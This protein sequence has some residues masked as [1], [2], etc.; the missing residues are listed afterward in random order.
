MSAP[1]EA[2]YREIPPPARLAPWVECVWTLRAGRDFRQNVLPDGCSDLLLSSWQGG[3]R[4]EVIGAMTRC[5][6]V[7]VRA[8]EAFVGIRFRPGRGSAALPGFEQLTDRTEPLARYW[9]GAARSL[10]GKLMHAAAD[11]EILE[12]VAQALDP[13]EEEEESA[14]Q[15][16]LDLQAMHHGMLSLEELHDTARLGPRQFRRVCLERTGMTPKLLS[17]IL[18]FRRVA[19]ALER[20]TVTS[21][22]ALA[23]DS[24]YCDQA[25]LIRDFRT[26]AGAPPTRHRAVREA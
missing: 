24:G 10:A 5:Q 7:K 26:F 22:A 16:A 17:R 13:L 25:H 23:I 12:A 4:F 14:V 19:N 1:C 3:Y 8:G 6:E 11:G 20:G 15:R 18:R 2:P 9:G 21:L